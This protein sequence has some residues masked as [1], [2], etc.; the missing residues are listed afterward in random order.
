M[1]VESLLGDL[2]EGWKYST[3]GELCQLGGGNIQTGPFE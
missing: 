3:T 1:D 2:P